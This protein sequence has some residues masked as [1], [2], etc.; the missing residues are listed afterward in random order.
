MT[1]HKM[2]LKFAT[3]MNCGMRFAI[4]IAGMP[5]LAILSLRQRGHEW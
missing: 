4:Q 3:H 5:I 2:W 1:A